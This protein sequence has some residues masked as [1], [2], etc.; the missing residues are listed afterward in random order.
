MYRT[1]HAIRLGFQAALVAL[2]VAYGFVVSSWTGH[3]P[4]KP[5]QQHP[6]PFVNHGTFYISA[7]DQGLNRMMLIVAALLVALWMAARQTELQWPEG[8]VLRDRVCEEKRRGWLIKFQRR[9][10]REWVR[11]RP[12]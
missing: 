7:H 3:R 9:A 4:L 2:L 12:D 10:I 5:D 1:V 8:R 11:D 6:F